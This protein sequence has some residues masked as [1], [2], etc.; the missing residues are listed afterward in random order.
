MKLFR[1][2]VPV[3]HYD[4]EYNQAN[5][6]I[7]IDSSKSNS[8]IV[9]ANEYREIL[10]DYEIDGS[11][12]D[13]DVYELCWQARGELKTLFTGANILG[14]GIEDIITK[15]ENG[16][17]GIEIHQSRHKITAVFDNFIFLFQ[18]YFGITPKRINNWEW[19][20]NTL[21]EEY[22]TKEHKKG[23]KDYFK[24]KGGR[25]AN[26]KDDVTDAVCICTYMCS[27]INLKVVTKIYEVSPTGIPYSYGIYPITM[28][29]PQGSK[30]FEVN[31]AHTLKQNMDTMVQM[32]SKRD[33]YGYARVPLEFVPTEWIYNGTFKKSYPKGV[34]EVLVVVRRKEQ[35]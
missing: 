29:M 6:V 4:T 16:Y 35:K 10:H 33:A 8:A 9:V 15:K 11:G 2:G 3:V 5:I 34:T 1:D 23:S 31:A 14:V 25:W 12:S 24:D 32:M 17:K 28:A 13:V 22:R 20:V 26:R 19:K 21:P 7:G 18:E 27:L 30:E